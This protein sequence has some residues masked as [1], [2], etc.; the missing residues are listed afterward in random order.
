[1]ILMQPVKPFTICYLFKGQTY[2][3]KQKLNKFTENIQSTKSIWQT[4]TKYYQ[5]SRIIGLKD[6][7]LLESLISE[8]FIT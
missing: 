5:A 8:I 4:L 7:P 6:S 3:A 2:V 1:M